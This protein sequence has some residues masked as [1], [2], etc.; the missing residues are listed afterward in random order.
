MDSPVTS[1]SLLVRIRDGRDVE[2]WRQFVQ[3]YSPVVYG[4]V[5]K[6]GLQDADAADLMQ[7]VLRSVTTAAGRL[8]YDPARGG[9][10]AWLY[11]VTRNKLYSFLN[12]RRHHVQ[13]TGDSDAQRRLLEE[14]EKDHAPLWDQEYDRS[15]FNWAAE[16][17]RGSFQDRTWQAFWRTAV[18]GHDP[19]A[20]A[21]DLGLSPGSVYVAK[22]RVLSR[23]R[24]Q[25]QQLEAE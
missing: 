8:E 18:E 11:T 16:R 19:V 23:L 25:V 15:V 14:P 10:R 5:R 4:F 21:R 9:F 6:R 12:S 22:S 7:E 13:G 2:A 20:V 1:A 3:V 17:V 24:E